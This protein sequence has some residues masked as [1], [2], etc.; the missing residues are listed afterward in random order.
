MKQEYKP[1]GET[2]VIKH[3]EII[4]KAYDKDGNPTLFAMNRFNGSINE[5]IG[6]LVG[7]IDNL[8]INERMDAFN[9]GYDAGVKTSDAQI[10]EARGTGA[11]AERAYLAGL[12]RT[13][14]KMLRAIFRQSINAKQALPVSDN[15]AQHGHEIDSV[16][17]Q[18]HMMVEAQ[19]AGCEG[20]H[21]YVAVRPVPVE[22]H[23]EL[24]RLKEDISNLFGRIGNLEDRLR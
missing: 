7:S 3:D 20:Q 21:G 8:M 24:L 17:N 13:D 2:V 12:W 9:K 19:V 4:G 22:V 16:G 11:I 5:A 18:S 1:G 23:G 15:D 14:R 10:Q 6:S